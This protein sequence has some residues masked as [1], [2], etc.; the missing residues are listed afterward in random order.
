MR[1]IPTQM[2]R[3]MISRKFAAQLTCLMKTGREAAGRPIRGL[4][5]TPQVAPN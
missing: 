1:M 3:L 5:I 2:M 4:G